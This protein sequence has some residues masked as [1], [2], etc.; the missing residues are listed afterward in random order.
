MKWKVSKLIRYLLIIIHPSCLSL[1]DNGQF[2]NYRMIYSIYLHN[3]TM[4]RRYKFE[5][6][7]TGGGGGYYI[8]LYFYNSSLMVCTSTCYFISL[9]TF[10]QSWNF[11]PVLE[12]FISLGTFHQSC[13]ISPV[14][15]HFISHGIF[16]Q[17]WN[18]SPVL[19][20]FTC[21]DY[22]NCHGIFH[23]SGTFHLSWNISPVLEYFTS[24][25]HFFI[26]Y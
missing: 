6:G 4:R 2:Y 3:E 21:L 8:V 1:T 17:S 26:I 24:W 23:L 11:S 16:F 18:I 10:Y 12:L 5:W 19:K 14:L 25:E 9:R 13:N 7:Y 20:H 15:E 22:F